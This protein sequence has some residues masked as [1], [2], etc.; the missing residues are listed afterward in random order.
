M[1]FWDW[2]ERLLETK[3]DVLPLEADVIIGIGIDVS[4]DGQKASPQSKAVAI[5][6]LKLFQKGRGKNILLS[7]GYSAGAITEAK[8]MDDIIS[9]EVSKPKIILEEKSYRTYMNADYTLRILKEKGWKSAIIVAQ[10]WHARRVRAT[11]RKRWIKSGIHFA[12]IKARSKYRSG[13]KNESNSQK[14]LKHFLLFVFWDNLA[15]I[16]SKLRDYC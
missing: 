5:K 4:K 3:D 11:F 9:K 16:I 13:P 1:D 14:R 12:V 6:V 7:G 8:A 15:F 2:L 10:Q